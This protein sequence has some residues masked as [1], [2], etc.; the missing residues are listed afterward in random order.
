MKIKNFKV[1]EMD[2]DDPRWPE[3]NVINKDGA[4]FDRIFVV[5]IDTDDGAREIYH[6]NNNYAL[7]GDISDPL[8]LAALFE[9]TAAAI[10]RMDRA[11][12]A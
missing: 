2:K 1:Y 11:K 9:S 8:G 6:F 12:A 10:K 7:R 3:T 4:T 5:A